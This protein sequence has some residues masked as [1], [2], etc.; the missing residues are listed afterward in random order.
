MTRFLWTTLAFMK[1]AEGS[2]GQPPRK[3]FFRRPWISPG[4]DPRPE[5]IRAA[6][7]RVV[8]SDVLR[9]SP[10][11]V[12]VLRFIVEATL[13]GESDRVK[14]HTIAVEALGRGE[15]FDPQVDPIVRVEARR[16]RRALER[17]YAGPG[18]TDQVIIELPR[19]QYV[20]TFRRCLLQPGPIRRRLAAAIPRAWRVSLAAFVLILIG[21]TV[22]A[23]TGFRSGLQGI[24]P[25]VS[26]LSCGS[27]MALLT[28]WP[29]AFPRALLPIQRAR[30]SFSRPARV[31]TGPSPVVP[32]A[33]SL[34][35]SGGS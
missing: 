13:R 1:M 28:Q 3:A 30:A 32:A 31:R 20:P 34:R 16:L 23:E 24:P 10:Q 21:T 14:G 22:L 15:D 2:G 26:R 33:F 18:A 35:R 17:Y 9:H 29:N 27:A 25:P 7:D 6:L 8:A 11:L 19:G 4:G 5:E 12:A